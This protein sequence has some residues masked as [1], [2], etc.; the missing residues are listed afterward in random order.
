MILA[1]VHIGQINYPKKS[2]LPVTFNSSNRKDGVPLSSG[3]NTNVRVGDRVFHIQ[4][5]DRGAHH[6]LIDTVVYLDGR[7]LHRRSS[8][9]QDLTSSPDFTEELLRRRVEDHHRSVIEALREGLLDIDPAALEASP[10]HASGTAS[11]IEIRLRKLLSIVVAASATLELEVVERQT[12]R[13]I[14]AAVL[15]VTLEGAQQPLR[16]DGKTDDHGVLQL[17]FPMPTLGSD[18]GVF[19]VRARAGSDEEVIRYMV[20][21]RAKS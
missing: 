14:P 7:V 20:R 4:T 6:P 21:A 1:L 15:E 3:F 9:Y 8:S 17:H 12:Q 13:P 18:G 5:E 19:V 2:L 11:A 10:G 16:L